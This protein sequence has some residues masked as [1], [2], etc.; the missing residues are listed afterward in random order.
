M[1]SKLP[2]RPITSPN[3]KSCLMKIAHS[4]THIK[5]LCVGLKLEKARDIIMSWWFLMKS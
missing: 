3:L 4:E 2:S 5:G 1:N